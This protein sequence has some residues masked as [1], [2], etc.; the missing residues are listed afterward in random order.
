MGLDQNAYAI[1]RHE[2]NLLDSQEYKDGELA[3]ESE[4]GL[5]S[6]RKHADLEGYMANLAVEK[7]VVS[8]SR[9]FN[10]EKVWLTEGDLLEL[11]AKVKGDGLDTATG[12]FWGSSTEDDE[13]ST[14]L[15]IEKALDAIK[16]GKA[17]YYTSW[18]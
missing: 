18:W 7:G 4:E 1:S 14:L 13:A 12:F 17:V 8:E 9:D 5:M 6:W 10:C 16:S 2:A 11:R 15:F 3:I